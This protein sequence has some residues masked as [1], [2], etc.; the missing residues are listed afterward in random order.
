MEKFKIVI[1]ETSREVVNVQAETE[2]E[3]IALVLSDYKKGKVT[4]KPYSA[5]VRR[6]CNCE[7]WDGG[8]ARVY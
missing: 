1:E 8:E 2:A 7:V 4:L 3:A 6:Y 5:T